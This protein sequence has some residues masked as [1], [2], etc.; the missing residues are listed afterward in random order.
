MSLKTFISNFLTIS[1]ANIQIASL[2]TVALGIFFGAN[3][4]SAVLN[5]HTLIYIVLFFVSLT[6]SCNLNCL[7]D[8]SV[9]EKY[10]TYM[11]NALKSLGRRNVKIILLVE[12][13]I[14]FSLIGCLILG[15][16]LI[17]SL[18]SILGLFFGIIYSM[19]PLRLKKRGI[20]SPIPVLIGLYTLPLLGGWYLFNDS[21][22]PTF[23][24]FVI[25]YALMNE[26]FTLVNTCEDY[27]EDKKER[28]ITWAHVFGLKKTLIMALLFSSSGFLCLITLLM[29]INTLSISYLFLVLFFFGIMYS[30]RDVY[31]VGKGKDLEKS[32]KKYGPKMRIWFMITRYPLFFTTLFLLI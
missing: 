26:G 5:L 21:L 16:Y 23:L 13:F 4:L 25:L 3:S 6:F 28:I 22:S 8:L 30:V 17:T 24:F 7:Y 20:L 10:K 14:I 29:Q 18:F 19:K 1:R 12:L 15:N 31:L 32:A 27:S 9:D 2:P 11:S